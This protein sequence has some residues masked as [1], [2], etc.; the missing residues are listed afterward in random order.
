MFEAF[1]LLVSPVGTWEKI[2]KANRSVVASFFL[3]LLPLILF[4]SLVESYAL[5]RWGYGRGQF[6]GVATAS[7]G[8]AVRY[9][10]TQVVLELAMVF[11]GAQLL[12]WI[13]D[14]TSDRRDYRRCFTTVAYS[15]GPVF[16]SHLLDSIPALNTWVCW[17]IGM[18]LSASALYLAIPRVLQPDQT[19]GFGVYLVTLLELILLSAICHLIV[20]STLDGRVFG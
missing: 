9:G 7:R 5:I 16:L 17:A 14:T 6:D 10:L 1:Q 8:Q 18:T 11:I 3:F 15:L 19:K 2:A 4:T 13:I 12:Q 20:L